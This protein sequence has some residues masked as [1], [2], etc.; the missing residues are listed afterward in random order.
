MA[1]K[2]LRVQENN[3][4]FFGKITKTLTKI[5]IPTKVG[6]NGIIIGVKRNNLI[7]A[8]ENYNNLETN[9]TEKQETLSKKYEDMYA[10]YLE[11]IDKY[12]MDS[13]Y[14]KV[15]SENATDFEK[16]AL[17][18]YYTIIQLKDTQYLEYK[19][20]KQKYLI[21]LDYES[22][23]QNK[24]KL[25]ER[26]KRFYAS[27]MEN[28]YKGILKNYSIQ[29]A[30]SKTTNQ[31]KDEIYNKIFDTLEEYITEILPIKIEN[32]TETNYD[33]IIEEYERFNTFL[34][35]KLDNVDIIKKKLAL[36]AISRKLF[37][38]S[39]PL[40][41]AE[42]CYVQLLKQTRKIMIEESNDS[43]KE[44]AFNML[45]DL[46]EEYNVKLLS[47][48][49]YWDKPAQREEYKKFWDEFCQIARMKDK[50]PNEYETKREILFVKNDLKA[51]QKNEKKYIKIIKYYK[52]RLV[53]LGV[54]RKMPNKCKTI[55][56]KF[57]KKKVIAK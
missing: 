1:E 34:A 42:Q 38:H 20:R 15:K 46:I 50:A 8:F 25:I 28:L 53:T 45:M 44:F 29:L 49:I 22:I 35:G 5:L 30:D 3:K 36:L 6:I 19:Y 51:L 27:K 17:S 47:T 21:E 12:I 24:E 2:S 55:N 41:V 16:N 14:N 33:E 52:D 56:G 39:L 18:N 10:L 23:N 7:K 4:T 13:I 37:T 43:K 40:I 26:Y 32:Q 54:L 9:D 48:K 57:E 31:S 11:S